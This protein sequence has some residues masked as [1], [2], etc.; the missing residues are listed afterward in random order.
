MKSS[1][2][3][4]PSIFKRDVTPA[5]VAPIIASVAQI[6]E[7]A[8]ATVP[9][10]KSPK[11]VDKSLFLNIINECPYAI[12]SSQRL[13]VGSHGEMMEKTRGILI[14]VRMKV[15]QSQGR[16]ALISSP[17]TFGP[18]N[19]A[20]LFRRRKRNASNDAYQDLMKRFQGRDNHQED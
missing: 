19:S 10:T 16:Q 2:S 4:R 1:A 17:G 6:I 3:A 8:I 12:D 11:P 5:P 9:I 15:L 13:A 7:V 18:S 20:S 14:A